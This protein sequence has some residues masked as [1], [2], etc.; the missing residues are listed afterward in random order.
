MP[1]EEGERCV[2]KKNKF[3]NFAKIVKKLMTQ[4]EHIKYWSDASDYDMRVASDM[5]KTGHYLYVGFL[6][7]QATEK[8]LKA[9]WCKVRDLTPL[10]IHTLT[11]LATLTGLWEEMDETQKM[12]LGILE[13]LNIACRYPDYKSDLARMLNKERSTALI[14][15]TLQLQTWIK[16]QF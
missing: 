4:E 14:K 5:L 11:R 7:H 10:K 13:P 16:E 1:A 15:R 12:E 2:G 3:I 8:L 9:Y 6:C